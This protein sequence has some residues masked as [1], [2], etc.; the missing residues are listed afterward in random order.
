[1]VWCTYF[2]SRSTNLVVMKSHHQERANYFETTPNKGNDTTHN[3]LVTLSNILRYVYQDD[4]VPGTVQVLCRVS[5]ASYAQT[6][7][8][9][10]RAVTK[11]EV[12]VLPLGCNRGYLALVESL[13]VSWKIIM[14]GRRS[15]KLKEGIRKP[16][17]RVKERILLSG[18]FYAEGCNVFAAFPSTLVTGKAYYCKRIL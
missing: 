17:Y 1:M 16:E 11:V 2:P 18:E 15:S 9:I 14:C 3:D 4:V 10:C 6:C 13:K 5:L 8:D 7:A 12:V